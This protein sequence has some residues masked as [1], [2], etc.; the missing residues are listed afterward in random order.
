MVDETPNKISNTV[1]TYKYWLFLV[2]DFFYTLC[3]LQRIIR[4]VSKIFREF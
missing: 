4:M 3:L 2:I 1:L